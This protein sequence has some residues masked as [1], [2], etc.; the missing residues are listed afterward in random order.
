MLC[1]EECSC[2]PYFLLIV[3]SILH[4]DTALWGFICLLLYGRPLNNDSEIHCGGRPSKEEDTHEDV[5]QE[6]SRGWGWLKPLWMTFNLNL[7][8]DS[9]SLSSWVYP[10]ESHH[11]VLEEGKKSWRDVYCLS[12][13]RDFFLFHLPAT[14]C[15]VLRIEDY[16]PNMRALIIEIH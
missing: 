2:F 6:E 10:W 16:N 7:F 4:V 5:E 12:H 15:W 11:L 3:L 1:L 8:Q 13:L 9:S 14:R